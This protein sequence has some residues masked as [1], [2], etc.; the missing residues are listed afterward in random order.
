MIKK[1]TPPGQLLEVYKPP[2]GLYYKGNTNCLNKTCISIVGTRKY[3]DYG[4][5]MTQKIIEEL[6]VLDIAIV[7]GLA[8]GIDT[9]AHKTALKL[10]IPTIAVLGSGLNNIYPRINLNL[11]QEI[12]QNGLLLSEYEPEAPPLSYNFPQRNRI[13]S[14]LSVATIVIEAPEKSGALITARFALEQG[15]EIFVVP[16]DVD[17]TNSKGITNLLQRGG[18]YPVTCGQDIIEVLKIQPHLFPQEKSSQPIYKF[19]PEEAQIIDNMQK[20]RPITLEEIAYK[21]SLQIEKILATLSILE[22]KGLVSTKDGKYLR[23]C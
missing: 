9:I 14:G 11:A 17:R 18:A 20:R 12:T 10:G 21:S 13:I 5:F 2:N 8:I 23:K 7:S 15:R 22:I 3:T 4:E 6:A 1:I 19:T 16:G